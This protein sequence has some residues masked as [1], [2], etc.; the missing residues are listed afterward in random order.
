M[1]HLDE[2][3]SK[4]Y[5]KY[6]KVVMVLFWSLKM[7]QNSLKVKAH[8]TA[9]GGVLMYFDC[10]DVIAIHQQRGG[11]RERRYAIINSDGRGKRVGLS[12]GIGGWIMATG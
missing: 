10:Q 2:K 8:V 6:I 1:I 5:Q 3:R 4:Y 12:H 9:R 11:N 7:I